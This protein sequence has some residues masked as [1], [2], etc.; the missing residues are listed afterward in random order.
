MKYFV[1]GEYEGVRVELWL[2]I[3]FA[4]AAL[5]MRQKFADFLGLWRIAHHLLFLDG[6][7]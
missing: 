1:L 2:L 7:K 5:M 4:L 6:Q 3:R